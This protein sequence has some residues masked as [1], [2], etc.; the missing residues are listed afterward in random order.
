MKKVLAHL[1]MA[2]AVCV[3]SALSFVWQI[4]DALSLNIEKR[5]K[6]EKAN[7]NAGGGSGERG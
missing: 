2:S 7:C 5:D 4:P 6:L 1:A 3:L